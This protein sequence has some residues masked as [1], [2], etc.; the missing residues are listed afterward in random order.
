MSLCQKL[1]DFLRSYLGR[2]F[3]NDA[4]NVFGVRYERSVIQL[5][6]LSAGEKYN[7]N[8]GQKPTP[9]LVA[10]TKAESSTRGPPFVQRFRTLL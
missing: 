3:E 2:R 10:R 7:K 6:G 4:P 5:T 8:L 1:N 9:T